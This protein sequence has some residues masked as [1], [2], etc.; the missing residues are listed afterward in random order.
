M[1]TELPPRAAWRHQDAHDGFETVFFT[2]SDGYEIAGCTAAVQPDEA[3]FVQYAISI[4]AGWR[5]M[6]A[7]V[8]GRS[9][10]GAHEVRIT[11]DGTGHWEVDG[12]P[13]P[14]LDGCLDVDLES[15]ACTN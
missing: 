9:R 2:P 15:S 6:N 11:G 8:R 1:F 13:V 14:E 7:R 12:V 4:D 10:L 3:W 5:T